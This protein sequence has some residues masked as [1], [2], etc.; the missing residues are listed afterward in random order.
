[1]IGLWKVMPGYGYGVAIVDEDEVLWAYTAG[2]HMLDSQVY[3]A[4]KEFRVPKDK[5][6]EFALQTLNEA[7]KELGLSDVK[8]YRD[9]ELIVAEKLGP[10]EYL[11]YTSGACVYADGPAIENYQ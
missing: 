1:M 6:K 2:N 3:C 5:L 9:K 10:F 11:Y 7:I 8:I 4:P